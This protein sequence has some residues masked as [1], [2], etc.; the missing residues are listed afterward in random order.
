MLNK[1]LTY[2]KTNIGILLILST[3][4]I[5]CGFLIFNNPKFW[6]CI[7]FL[8]IAW[9]HKQTITRH[10]YNWWT[11]LLFSYLGVYITLLLRLKLNVVLAASLGTFLIQF[12]P[13]IPS[14]AKSIFY[15]GAFAAMG[16]VNILTPSTLLIGFFI[17]TFAWFSQNY[18]NGIGGKLGTIGFFGAL[19]HYFIFEYIYK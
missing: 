3:Q 1:I 8:I 17:A 9:W 7:V 10:Q 14:Y 19:T 2:F 12:I 6:Y 15:A 18:H 13:K 16:N 11:L 5:F 4:I